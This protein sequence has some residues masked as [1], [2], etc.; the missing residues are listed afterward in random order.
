[1]VLSAVSTVMMTAHIHYRGSID[2]QVMKHFSKS[3]Q[4]KK[5]TQNVYLKWLEDEYI[6]IFGWTIPLKL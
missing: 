3:V 6:F 2:E 1:M 5:Q 4:M